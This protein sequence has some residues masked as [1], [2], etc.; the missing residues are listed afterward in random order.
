MYRNLTQELQGWAQDRQ[1]IPLL[2][3]GARQVGKSYLVEDFG[4]THFDNMVI[5]NFELQPE[6]KDCFDQLNPN[7]ILN[8]LETRLNQTIT[9]GKTL[10]FLDEIQECPKAIMALR[11]FKEKLPTLHVISAGSLLEFVLHDADFRM[12]VGRVQYLYV[13]PLSFKEYLRAIQHDK[14]VEYIEELDWETTIPQNLHNQLLNLVRQYCI[15]G[16]MPAVIQRYC[17]TQSWQEAQ[18]I[19]TTLLNT[20]RNDFGKYA[21]HVNHR[22]LETLFS[23]APGFVAQQFKYVSIDREI[24]ARE[25][26]AALEKLCLAGVIQKIKATS[27]VQLPLNSTINEKKFKLLFLDIGLVKRATGLSTTVLL[28]DDL[29]LINRGAITEQFVGQELLAAY[30]PYDLAELF[31]WARDKA[32]S[33][34]EVDYVI[35]VAGEII[36]VEVKSGS[37]G[38]LRSLKLFMEERGSKIGI[39]VSQQPLMREENIL[40][41]P[42][43]LVSEIERLTEK[44][45]RKRPPGSL[46]VKN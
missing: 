4:N 16:G 5:V 14:L 28:Q 46:F 19:Q 45:G 1:P 23:K 20:Y 15:L 30:D 18:K 43:Y 29:L 12:P 38:R 8:Q 25:I 7:F 44:L 32:G 6:L 33:Q 35:Q 9:P 39:R 13:K 24:Q 37:T 26:K 42:L 34:A 36:P 10:L 31:F 40:S 21:K 17:E 2:L 41:I 27:G 3:R 11:Y 22:N